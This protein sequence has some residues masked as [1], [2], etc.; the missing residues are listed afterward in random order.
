MEAILPIEAEVPTFST[1]VWRDGYT[2]EELLAARMRQIERRD[3]DLDEAEHHLWRMH[4]EN[5]EYFDNRHVLRDERLS[6]GDLVLLHNTTGSKDMSSIHKLSFRWLGPYVVEEVLGDSGAYQ[7]R[8]LDGTSRAGSVHGNQ[9]KRFYP[10][11]EAEG[12]PSELA[13]DS[14][15]DL[16]TSVPYHNESAEDEPNHDEWAIRTRRMTRKGDNMRRNLL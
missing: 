6:A 2:T 13:E 4:E 8:E 16:D 5:K 12:N 10:R 14:D 9:L 1:I 11:M 3:V 7:I 15:T